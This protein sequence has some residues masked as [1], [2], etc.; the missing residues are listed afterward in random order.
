MKQSAR[1]RRANG[2]PEGTSVDGPPATVSV[3]KDTAQA[4]ARCEPATVLNDISTTVRSRF[5]PR[6][7]E[8]VPVQLGEGGVLESM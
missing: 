8:G 6:Q 1:Q 2:P 4:L 3:P 7:V 5:A